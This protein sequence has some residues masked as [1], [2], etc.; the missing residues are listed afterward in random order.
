MAV[1]LGV[2]AQLIARNLAREYEEPG[3][4]HGA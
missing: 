2:D 3:S 4:N 1:K